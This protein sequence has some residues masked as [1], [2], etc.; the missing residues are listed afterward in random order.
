MRAPIRVL[1]A[2]L[3]VLLLSGVLAAAAATADSTSY[4]LSGIEINATPA[5]FVGGVDGGGI[6][7]ALIQHGSLDKNENGTTPFTGSF[8]IL[9]PESSVTGNVTNGVLVASKPEFRLFTCTQR[10]TFSGAPFT[11]SRA[12]TA[13]SGQ[14]AGILTHYGTINRSTATPTCDAFAATENITVTVTPAG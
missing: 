10:F 8:V 7:G 1:L 14:A 9:R 6:W 13:V 3:A 11:G 2:A 4:G 5:T 12:G